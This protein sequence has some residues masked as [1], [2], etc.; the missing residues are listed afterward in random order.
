MS[1]QAS[2]AIWNAFAIGLKA[3]L[4]SYPGQP[5]DEIT[6]RSGAD[7]RDW[8]IGTPDDAIAHIERMQAETGGFGGLMLTTHEWTGTEKLRRS[9]ELFA[10]YVIPHFRGHTG[11]YRDEWQRLRQAA[12]D[13]G[14][15]LAGAGQLSN[16]V[17]SED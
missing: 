5:A 15:K 8:I 13:G 14:V 4:R 12:T 16:L 10:R 9:L 2:G 7:R 6:P 1:K 17:R 11:G 3:P